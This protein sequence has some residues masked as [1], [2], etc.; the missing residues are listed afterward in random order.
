MNVA[1]GGPPGTGGMELKVTGNGHG[2]RLG[3]AR[4][5]RVKPTSDLGTGV[6]TIT[7][8]NTV[9]DSLNP[10]LRC[11]KYHYSAC[12]PVDLEGFGPF[13]VGVLSGQPPNGAMSRRELVIAAWNG[14]SLGRWLC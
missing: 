3:D 14:R 8:F 12:L 13:M 4:L 2:A 5:V 1:S 11:D 9:D 10:G 7:F 6:P